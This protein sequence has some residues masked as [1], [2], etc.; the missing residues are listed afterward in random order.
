MKKIKIQY[1]IIG[2][3]LVILG[4]ALSGIASAN[5]PAYYA[6]LN[7]PPLA[8]SPKVFA[9]VWTILYAMIGIVGARI[10][11]NYDQKTKIL[12][13]TQLIL[14]FLYTVFFFALQSTIL[15]EIDLIL[16]LI[17]LFILSMKLYKQNKV[18]FFVF[19]PYVIWCCFA[20]YLNTGVLLLNP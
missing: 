11:F 14:N 8:P 2:V 10:Y 6:T 7:K 19:L 18:D 20:T 3:V 5:A 17:V 1:Y 12:F 15:A 4:G 16:L 9:P 13:V